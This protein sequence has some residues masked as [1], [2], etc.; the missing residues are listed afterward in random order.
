MLDGGIMPNQERS[1]LLEYLLQQNR[2]GK[3]VA[4]MMI[5]GMIGLGDRFLKLQE[6]DMR[7]RNA[8]EV[9]RNGKE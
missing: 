1:E 9:M 6:E 3:E 2:D 8:R 5:N 4:I 7:L